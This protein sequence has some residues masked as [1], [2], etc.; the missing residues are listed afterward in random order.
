MIYTLNETKGQLNFTIDN[1]NT[2]IIFSK[3][4]NAYISHETCTLY[5]FYDMTRVYRMGE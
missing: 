1:S 2:G 5:Y 4:S 3:L